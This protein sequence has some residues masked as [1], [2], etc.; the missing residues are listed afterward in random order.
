MFVHGLQRASNQGGLIRVFVGT[1]TIVKE[2]QSRLFLE[3]SFGHGKA[4]MHSAAQLLS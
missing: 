1:F 4:C 3:G 2:N